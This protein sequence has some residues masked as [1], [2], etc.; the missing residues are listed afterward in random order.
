MGRVLEGQAASEAGLKQDD[1]IISLGGIPIGGQ[2]QLIDE[3][4]KNGGKATEIVV[5]RDGE[6]VPL[7]RSSRA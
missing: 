2:G 1:K 6:N 5:R 7:C 4:Q 3:L